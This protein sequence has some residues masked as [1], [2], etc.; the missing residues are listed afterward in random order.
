MVT[1]GRKL[2]A[3]AS[4]REFSLF[5]SIVE[6]LILSALSP[7]TFPHSRAFQFDPS[8]PT[9]FLLYSPMFS[10]SLRSSAAAARGTTSSGAATTTTT[11]RGVVAPASQRRR[12]VK[13]FAGSDGGCCGGGGGGGQTPF[14]T[15]SSLPPSVFS[16]SSGP[17]SSGGGGGG[18]GCSGGGA[19]SSSSSSS[20][21]AAAP[22]SASFGG[23][24]A[25]SRADLELAAAATA[26]PGIRRKE[27]SEGGKA[28]TD[29]ALPKERFID[30]AAI[31]R[32]EL[33]EDEVED[34]E[35]YLDKIV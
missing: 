27:G 14:S 24:V 1:K 13:A 12:A 2:L 22:F 20:Q 23:E 29:G 7:L 32:G 26:K 11:A 5:C 8:L 3:S 34:P 17:S 31:L 9:L 21:A 16:A 33:Q 6:I 35:A 18:C 28:G 15:S 25:V 19:P 10:S 30:V 4:K